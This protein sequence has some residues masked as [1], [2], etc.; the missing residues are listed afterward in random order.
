MDTALSRRRSRQGRLIW[1]PRAI[2]SSAPSN[3]FG[4]IS[5]RARDTAS[6]TVSFQRLTS[7]WAMEQIQ[8]VMPGWADVR[9]LC[10]RR[11]VLVVVDG[12]LE[13]LHVYSMV[14]RSSLQ[15]NK[16]C[17]PCWPLDT[18]DVHNNLNMVLFVVHFRHPFTTTFDALL[19]TN[20]VNTRI[21]TILDITMSCIVPNSTAE[22]SQ[23][24]RTLG[25]AHDLILLWANT[26]WVRVIV[27]ALSPR[28]KWGELPACYLK[29]LALIPRLLFPLGGT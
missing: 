18:Q 26:S 25:H 3:G 12:R 15:F 27:V 20:M 22:T 13:C 16:F 11:D 2:D 28:G 5:S 19:C 14:D 24:E 4:P 6:Q 9:I 17:I 23:F 8:V 21:W 7:L 10:T 29:Y 1:E